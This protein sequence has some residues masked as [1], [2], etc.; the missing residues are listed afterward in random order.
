MKYPNTFEKIFVANSTFDKEMGRIIADSKFLR[1][2]SK[3]RL[4]RSLSSGNA[5]LVV[6]DKVNVTRRYIKQLRQWFAIGRPMDMIEHI[7]FF[8]PQCIFYQKV[9]MQKEPNMAN[10]VIANSLP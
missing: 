3:V 4:Q 7:L 5:G 1:K 6:N 2:G 9:N 8:C 10:V